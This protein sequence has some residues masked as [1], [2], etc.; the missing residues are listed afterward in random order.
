[1]KTSVR[2][3]LLCL[4]VSIIA[5][6][7]AAGAEVTNPIAGRVVSL[8]APFAPGGGTD[9]VAR[10]IADKLGA[11]IDRAVIVDN[12][13]GANGLVASQYVAKARPDGE[14]LMF[15]SF[16]THV[17]E[18]LLAKNKNAMD[19]YQKKF[20]LV[21]IVAI[22]PLVLAVNVKSPFNDVNSTLR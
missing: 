10:L 3:V 7:P 18:P 21:S 8:V 4:G 16:S 6:R 15:G 22:T 19:E 20:V 5:A 14:T 13:P 17:I 1:M 2:A 9:I 11:D 12:K